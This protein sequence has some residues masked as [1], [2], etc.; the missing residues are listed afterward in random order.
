MDIRI[1]PASLGHLDEIHQLVR[2]NSGHQ[3]LLPRSRESIEESIHAW[4]VALEGSK[5]IGCG[6]LMEYDNGL[7]E[8]R[9][10]AVTA[11]LRGQGIGS[12][13]VQELIK[14]ARKRGLR[15]M[16]ALTRAAP[17]F[18]QCGFRIV[19]IDCFPEKVMRFCAACPSRDACDE[20]AVVLELTDEKFACENRIS[21]SQTHFKLSA[22]S[23]R[24][25]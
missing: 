5:V 16:F 6:S 14:A 4:V 7:V 18:C 13:I 22:A 15:S 21:G 10:L 1:Q 24:L 3:S 17:L 20:T 12:R 23:A 9:S 19:P 11:R 8:V 25:V 2:E